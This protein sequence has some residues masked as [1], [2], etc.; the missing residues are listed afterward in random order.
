MEWVAMR[1]AVCKD[2]CTILCCRMCNSTSHIADYLAQKEKPHCNDR[3]KLLC[4]A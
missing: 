4:V 1:G 3:G 2:T